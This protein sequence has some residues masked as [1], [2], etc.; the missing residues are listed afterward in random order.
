M[1]RIWRDGQRKEVWI[2]RLITT[3]TIEEK[4]FQR[5]LVKQ[6]MSQK[7]M[8]AEMTE[9]DFSDEDLRDI[10]C[11]TDNTRSETVDLLLVR[12]LSLPLRPSPLP[13]IPSEQGRR[14]GEEEE[15]RCRPHGRPQGLEPLRGPQAVQG[16][17]VQYSLFVFL[18]SLLQDELSRKLETD[19]ISYVFTH[20]TVPEALTAPK[21][22]TLKEEEEEKEAAKEKEEES[23]ESE[24]K[25]AS[26]D[27]EI[28]V[29]AEAE[30]AVSSKEEEKETKDKAVSEKKSR[31]ELVPDVGEAWMFEL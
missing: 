21:L 19:R 5:Q 29:E 18:G 14:P 20:S 12:I 16:L 4:I 7:V 28:E 13:T 22:D 17:L 24:E 6:S 15:V 25:E 1:A 9:A 26:G 30:K 10:F 23:E 11:L 2:Y 27:G 3:G 31:A 8:H